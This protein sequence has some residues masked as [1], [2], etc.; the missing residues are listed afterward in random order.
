MCSSHIMCMCECL[1]RLEEG[2]QYLVARVLDSCEPF[3]VATG[4]KP[5]A[6]ARA[7]SAP[8]LSHLF[9]NFGRHSLSVECYQGYRHLKYFWISTLEHYPTVGYIF[10]FRV[11]LFHPVRR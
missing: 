9:F 4:T 2:N 5:G 1:W 8:W 6:F 7:A 10:S 3:C 11:E